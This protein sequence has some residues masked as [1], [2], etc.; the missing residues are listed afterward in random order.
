MKLCLWLNTAEFSEPPEVRKLIC[1]LADGPD[2]CCCVS[3][4][5]VFQ[6]N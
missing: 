4:S 5:I 6:M 2:G 3:Y 1:W